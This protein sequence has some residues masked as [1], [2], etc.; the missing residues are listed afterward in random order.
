MEATQIPP[1]LQALMSAQEMLGISMTAPG[2]QGE[3]PT[4]ASQILQQ[5]QM[6]GVKQQAGIGAMIQARQA[7]E[8]QKAA[9][10][11]DEIARR[12]AMMMQPRGVGNLP[13]QMQFKEGGIIG[14]NGEDGSDVRAV[15]PA[16]IQSNPAY[17]ELRRQ[18]ISAPEAY[19]QV[20]QSLAQTEAP[21]PQPR[22]L[23][24]LSPALDIER[25]AL[26]APV[27]E[28]PSGIYVQPLPEARMISSES[29]AQEAPTNQRTKPPS[30]DFTITQVQAPPPPEL[31][32]IDVADRP[33]RPDVA[34]I[35]QQLR[36]LI[37]PGDL[38]KQTNILR[39]I[40]A[41]R[42]KALEG[43]PALEQKG[44]AALQAAEQERQRLL[45]ARRE[46]DLLNKIIAW[47]RDVYTRGNTYGN[48]LEGIRLR[49]EQANQAKL[50]H[51][52]AV[53][54]LER[55]E[56]E[57]K[58][59]RFD[60]MEA[61]E[62]KVM[63]RQDKLTTNLLTMAQIAGQMAN[64]TYSAEMKLFGD[65]MIA[66]AQ[67]AAEAQK[68]KLQADANN[69]VRVS[70]AAS[71]WQ[72]RLNDAM[73]RINVALEKEFKFVQMQLAMPQDKPNPQLDAQVARMNQRMKALE[74]Q[75]GVD[76]IRAQ[77]QQ[78][79]S[80]MVAPMRFDSSGNPVK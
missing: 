48:V 57:R 73:Q 32:K 39:D 29:G 42:E 16:E 50:N 15:S 49:E 11:P 40:A 3:Q 76:D 56:Q 54:D 59:K 6:Q 24:S 69:M 30:S 61:L 14:Y 58:L 45:E 31:P 17:I 13:F 68:I 66:N 36:G 28:R 60:R 78:L 51:E 43:V 75:Y 71:A 4:V 1:G 5:A 53:I 67:L 7:Q 77:I 9:Q 63:E 80:Q 2:P 18:G 37:Q 21:Q 65:S 44:I 10:D 27:Q 55:A 74:K 35:G 19:R 41:Q 64:N 79:Q 47:G 33:S 22:P 8:R 34:A 38:D 20:E 25:K 46:G 52:R 12:V 72:S 23:G 62:N 26:S 70:N